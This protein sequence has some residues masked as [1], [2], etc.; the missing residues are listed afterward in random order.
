MAV[1]A[2]HSSSSG[3]YPHVCAWVSLCRLCLIIAYPDVSGQSTPGRKDMKLSADR[4]EFIRKTTRPCLIVVILIWITVAV[5]AGNG[6]WYNPSNITPRLLIQQVTFCTQQPRMM[7]E[8]AVS[9]EFPKIE[10]SAAEI[11]RCW[12][13]LLR[14]CLPS[15]KPSFYFRYAPHAMT[16]GKCSELIK[17]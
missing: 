7:V 10:I 12:W 5:M 3:V 9:S 8:P 13:L 6:Y 4:T 2:S 11:K 14:R 17:A 16:N 1:L 15:K